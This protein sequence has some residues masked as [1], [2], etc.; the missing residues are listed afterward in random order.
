MSRASLGL[1]APDNP[2]QREIASSMDS[3]I[4]SRTKEATLNA[5]GKRLVAHKMALPGIHRN[6]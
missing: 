3:T 1:P 5:K 2:I 6:R 4:P